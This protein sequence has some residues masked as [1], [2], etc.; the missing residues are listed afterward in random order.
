MSNER[1]GRWVVW[2]IAVALFV[3]FT[4]LFLAAESAGLESEDAWTAWLEPL[5]NGAGAGATAGVLFVVL[6]SDLLLPIP[7]SIVMTLSGSLLGV[8]GGTAINLSGAMASSMA[9]YAACRWMGSRVFHRLVGDDVERVQTWFERWGPWLI[10]LSR[11]V[12]M[13]TEIV[14]C[15]AG[16]HRMP[17]MRFS[18]LSL[19]GASPICVVY[20]WAGA[21][22]IGGLWLP[23][24]IALALPGLAWGVLSVA[25]RRRTTT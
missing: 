11:G 10:V 16:L 4:T 23:A 20:A 22:D 14:S 5:R 9:G 18:L 6:A 21:T 7:S 1:R 17:A 24:L 19:V 25:L 2:F 13:L 12:P 8:I 15:L 3:V